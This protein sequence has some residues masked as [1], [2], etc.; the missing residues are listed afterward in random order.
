MPSSSAELMEQWWT[1]LEPYAA[2]VRES[3]PEAL[4]AITQG[5]DDIV[6]VGLI[7]DAD[8]RTL[9]PVAL[10]R[11]RREQAAAADPA[12]A[13]FS[14]WCPDEWDIQAAPRQHTVL[15]SLAT[16][17][18][19]I[20]AGV[21]DSR[22]VSFTTLVTNWYVERMAELADDGFFETAYPGANVTFWVTDSNE[23]AENVVEWVELLN[24]PERCAPYVAWLR[25]NS[26]AG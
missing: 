16:A 25:A 11:A 4:A 14:A 7:T 2:E 13:V 22:W 6:G 3:I 12:L 8:A 21:D 24:P 17:V 20:A 18:D 10:S 23:P 26:A 15:D 9:V 5:R 1:A 19:R